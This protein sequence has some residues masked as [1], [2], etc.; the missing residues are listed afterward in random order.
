M[1]KWLM[2]AVCGAVTIGL[3]A[4]AWGQQRDFDI[5]IPDPAPV[6]DGT[7]DAVW[8]LASVQY[9][10]KDIGEG[11]HSDA[12][13]CSGSF[14]VL[15]DSDYLYVLI[16]VN[17]ESLNLDNPIADG[18]QDDSC[19]FYFDGDNHKG[20]QG[21]VGLVD[22]QYRFNWN[23]DEP[24]TYFYEYF[25]RPASMEG[26]EYM[27]EETDTGY[28]FEIKFPWTT[29]MAGGAAPMGK[30]VGIDC[31]INDDDDGA[32][33]DHQV[34]W[35]AAEGAGWNTPS[36]WG[37]A[38]VV[39]PLKASGPYPAKGATG[40]DAPLFKWVAGAGATTHNVYLSTSPDLGPEQL[41]GPRQPLTLFYYLQGLQPGTTYYWRVDEIEK[42]GTVHTGDMW[43]FTTQAE[44]AY[45]P[46]PADGANGVPLTATLAWQPA[47]AVMKHHVYL[48]ESLDAVTQGAADVDRGE[49]EDTTFDPNGLQG[50]T[51]YYWRVDE[52]VAGNVVKTG[53]V[54]SFATWLPVDDFESYNDEEGKGTRIYETWM[55]GFWD[56]SSGSTVGYTEPPF[57]EQ[58]TIHG[59]LQS[60]P[61]DYNNVNPPYYSEAERTF[62]PAQDW[63]AAGTDTL[64]LYV[65][66]RAK[67]TP[68]PLYLE[69][70][71]TANHTAVITHPDPAVVT[72]TK[73][74][75][76]QIPLSE[77]SA[78]GVDVTAVKTLIIG[79]GDKA[80]PAPDGSGLIFIDDIC[81]LMPVPAE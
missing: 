38:F 64:V 60:M 24:D 32:G 51:A 18:W 61:L 14:R 37:T 76:W 34:A 11:P 44:T 46:S 4:V 41:V 21:D 43:S 63:T 62:T 8:S 33:R 29:L 6:I 36:M 5:P 40:V 56:Q 27:M 69:V 53:P 77:L 7:V 75:E 59:G 9:M 35:H 73:W 10:T 12:K 79:I 49:V 80:N 20:A 58:K 72:A 81:L 19:E 39:A 25:H 68:A 78:A 50:A 66:G 2:Y 47:K 1:G 70:K 31:F 3:G 52:T 48:G 55:D 45:L 13:D 71:D 54:W 22:Y 28:R 74:V 17:D 30:L 57:A 65:R 42:N 15:H 26:V 16:D 67:N 23:P